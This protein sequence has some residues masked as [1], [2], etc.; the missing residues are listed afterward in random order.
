M[1]KELTKADVRKIVRD[2]IEKLVSKKDV[3]QI[4]KK[5][6]DSLKKDS[7]TRDV[8]KDMIRKTIV[9]QH[10]FMWEKSNFF[11]KQI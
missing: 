11:I 7:I 1:G 8:V 9:N 5:E 6:V 3:E 4:I 10:K 2:E